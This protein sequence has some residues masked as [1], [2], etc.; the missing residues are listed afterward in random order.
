MATEGKMTE[1]IVTND[2]F[3]KLQEEFKKRKT[4]EEIKNENF[5]LKATIKKQNEIIRNMCKDLTELRK[6]CR[7][8]ISRDSPFWD[9]IKERKDPKY[10]EEKRKYQ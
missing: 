9:Y 8:K 1:T 3:M 5:E 10:L 4:L 6:L 7:L 2:E